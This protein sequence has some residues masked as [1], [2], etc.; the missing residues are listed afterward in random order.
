MRQAYLADAVVG[1]P[2]STGA[3]SVGNPSDGDP[4]NG[5]E[6]TALGAYALY[7]LFTEME[8]VA[9][10]A[11]L[12]PDVD[13]LTQLRDAIL[14]LIDASGFDE[15]AG[16]AR[17]LQQSENLDDVNNAGTARANIGAA[18]LASPSFT[19]NPSAPTQGT[20]N[21]STRLATT[22]YVA[23]KIDAT[24]PPEGVTL[25]TRNEHLA[26][27]PP[28]DEAAVPAYVGDMIEVAR[29]ALLTTIEGGAAANRDTL[30]ELFDVLTAAIALKANIAA[31]TLTGNARSSTP[32]DDDDSTRIATT[33]WVRENG[34]VG[35]LD[36]FSL[37]THV[38]LTSSWAN[39]L[40]GNH[41]VD[42]ADYIV[43]LLYS[44]WAGHTSTSGS[45]SVGVRLMRGAVRFAGGNIP[46]GR[47]GWAR[48]LFLD[49]PGSAAQ[50]DYQL[51]MRW[52]WKR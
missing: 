7:Q 46:E 29:A 24:T 35:N 40:G 44:C 21:E 10:A 48:Q 23:D 51:Q 1:V 25:A 6:A 50:Y 20:G 32:P 3:T 4:A 45:P 15:A 36:F 33:G 26:N 31:P 37:S 39:L 12:T 28:N 16:D 49:K 22:Q 43:G 18:P 52:G 41:T 14:A 47:P 42:D 27:N 9:I 5:V 17:Y 38:R 34:G 8:N 11:G 13:T 19:G 2:A 30:D